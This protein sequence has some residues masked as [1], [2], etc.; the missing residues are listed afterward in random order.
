MIAEFSFV[1]H[2]VV[3]LLRYGHL[4]V[5][6][7]ERVDVVYYDEEQ[8]QLAARTTRSENEMPYG[9]P[10]N[11]NG[12]KAA[13]EK[14]RKGRTPFEWLQ[15]EALPWID[16]GIENINN[17]LLSELQKLVLMISVGNNDLRSS[18][19]LVFFYFRPGFSN[20][21]MTSEAKPVTM[22]EKDLVGHAY[23]ASVAALIA[24]AH[25]DK[26]MWDDFEQAFKANG[27]II[28][29][30]RSQLKQMRE[31]Y[32]DRLV[33][34]C[35]FY[36][37]NLSEQFQRNYQF[38]AGALEQIKRYEGEYFRL[39]NAIKAGVRIANNL[40]PAGGQ[41]VT[42]IPEFFLNFNTMQRQEEIHDVHLNTTLEKPFNY[43]NLIEN[44]VI[45]L[46]KN[47]IPL[48]AKNVAES[49]NPPVKHSAIKMYLNSN[50]DKVLKLFSF[51]KDKWP[52]LRTEFKPTYNL[53][54]NSLNRPHQRQ[55]NL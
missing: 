1:R 16:A 45:D 50:Y 2:P 4:L 12:C 30:L 6:G 27:A 44:I 13:L 52:L 48:T 55:S 34:S 26:F 31:M 35:R 19:D 18:S 9:E 5:P 40:H 36:L 41:E 51:Y 17:D 42:E 43:L 47:N 3:K 8:E 7:V 49:M 15:K 32:R 23:A 21:G 25:D 37:K 22:R 24:E 14:L 20:L 33:D 54:Q 29:N 28:E 11:I 46:R 38:S 39:E 53:L 10:M